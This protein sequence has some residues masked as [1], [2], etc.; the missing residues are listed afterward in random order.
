MAAVDMIPHAA[1]GAWLGSD[2]TGTLRTTGNLAVVHVLRLADGRAVVVKAR[3]AEDRLLGCAHVHRHLWRAGFPCPE[4]IAGP[5]RFG[6]L[7]VS[8]E[9]AVEPTAGPAAG[10]AVSTTRRE[11]VWPAS[12][13]GPLGT[14][15][16]GHEKPVGEAC[17]G[18]DAGAEVA[19]AGVAG[20]A[21]CS[22]LLARLIEMAPR[23]RDTPSTTP[24]PPWVRWHHEEGP[25]WPWPDDR[26]VD[27]HAEESWHDAAALAVRARLRRFAAEPVI[28]H[29]DFESH[30]IWWR[31][32][33]PLAVHDWDSVVAEPEAVIVGVAAAMWPAG[34]GRWG[35]TLQESGEFLDGYQRASGRR[36]N[37][38]EIEA[39]WAAGLWI[40]LFNAKKW[41][42]DGLD[43]LGRDEA[44]ERGRMAGL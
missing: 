23:V 10:P 44:R 15:G 11:A 34:D 6:E 2:V 36:F 16:D 13:S 12:T 4:P 7:A 14:T 3:P 29:C 22:A 5:T 30:N 19:G 21:E 39:A 18:F 1:I 37:R 20:A 38:E 33:V 27:L 35:A 9:M 25:I 40:R 41:R 28:G 17:G 43:G 8:A 32:D 42:L 31:G 26:D 24:S